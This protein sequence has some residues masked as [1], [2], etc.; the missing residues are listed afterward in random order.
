MGIFRVVYSDC[1]CHCQLMLSFPICFLFLS[2]YPIS[3]FNE[4]YVQLRA[5]KKS[6][7]EESLKKFSKDKQNVSVSTRKK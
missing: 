3:P 2:I 4:D 1:R 5:S 7:I 6:M